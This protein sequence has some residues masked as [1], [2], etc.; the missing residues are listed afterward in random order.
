M[1]ESW[2]HRKLF[3]FDQ[4]GGHLR[5]NLDHMPIYG[6]TFFGDISV[7]FRPISYFKIS[8]NSGQRELSDEHHKSYLC[9]FSV[10]LVFLPEKWAWPP[11]WRHRVQGLKTQSKSCST[12]YTLSVN[13]Y[14]KIMFPQFSSLNPPLNP[15]VT[16][17][18]RV[19]KFKYLLIPLV[20]NPVNCFNNCA[21]ST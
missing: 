15:K 4:S 9:C 19:S 1:V 12:L 11:V 2:F 18:N 6:H 3:I 10:I 8:L 13:C 17:N 5:S 20:K 16:R 14:L 21:K 7:I